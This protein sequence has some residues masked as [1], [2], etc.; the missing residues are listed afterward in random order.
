MGDR[1]GRFAI[2]P[3]MVMERLN[4]SQM[5]LYCALAVHADKFGWCWPSQHTLAKIVGKS[6]SWVNNTLYQL[7]EL[8]VIER[9]VTPTG[10]K[11]RLPISCSLYHGEV[12]NFSDNPYQPAD[13]SYQPA[14]INNTIN[15]TNNINPPIVPPRGT[16]VRP[17]QDGWG[18]VADEF[19]R[20]WEDY[21]RKVGRGAAVKAFE[22]AVRKV[23]KMTFTEGYVRSLIV[24][25]KS[26]LQFVP[27]LATWLNQERWADG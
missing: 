24:W 22:R 2:V 5:G 15:N 12:I 17:I 4:A 8:R 9:T 20:V 13:T 14:D 27:H 26:D 21:P 19:E 10:T 18:K 3:W 11:Y 23:D 7:D 16:S 1:E 6:Q 25:E